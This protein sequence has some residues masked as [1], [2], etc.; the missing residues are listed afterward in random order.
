MIRN[1]SYGGDGGGASAAAMGGAIG[2]D[3]NEGC[4]YPDEIIM[5]KGVAFNV[6]VCWTQKIASMNIIDDYLTFWTKSILYATDTVSY[7]YLHKYIYWIVYI[8]YLQTHDN[9]F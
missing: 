6:R 1:G 4:I 8:V 7:T 5:E 2:S 9:F 3:G